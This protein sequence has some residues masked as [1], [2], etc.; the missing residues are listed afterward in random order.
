MIELPPTILDRRE[1]F[2]RRFRALS[3]GALLSPSASGPLR[4]VEI[5]GPDDFVR[6]S[7]VASPERAATQ[8]ATRHTT[9]IVPGLLGDS[10][11]S[12]V[13]PFLCAREWLNEE[14]YDVRVVWLNGR[15]GAAFNGDLLRRRVRE[16]SEEVGGPLNLIGYSKGAADAVYMLGKYGDCDGAV[17]SLISLA[18]VVQGT[19]LAESTSRLAKLALRYLPLPGLGFGDGLALRD[20]SREHLASWWA[21]RALPHSIRYA[22]VLAVPEPERV[23]RVLQPGW[24]RLSEVDPRNDSQVLAPD[25]LLPGSELLA[26]INADHWA[27][28]LPIQERMPWVAKHFVTRNDFPRHALLRSMIDHVSDL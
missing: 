25:S 4:A 15:R 21:G 2:A 12:L 24:R 19:P 11:R 13:A 28:A 7:E 3:H 5:P 20:L 8:P 17:R 1:E 22:S 26:I 14:G 9:L 27:A 10:F 18:G 16:V 6:S 23:S